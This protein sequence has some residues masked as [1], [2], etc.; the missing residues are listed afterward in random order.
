MQQVTRV[1]NEQQEQ[2][3]QLGLLLTTV[4]PK[5]RWLLAALVLLAVAGGLWWWLGYQPETSM[6]YKTAPAKRM[7]LAVTVTA[8]GKV[9]PKDK[10]ELSSELSG[11]I[12]DVFV[13]YNDRVSEGQKLAQL[14]TSKISATVLQRKSSLRSAQA[15]VKTARANLE[16]AQ[17]NHQYYQNVWA[18]SEG[19]FPSQQTLD[20]ARITLAKAEASLEQA[21]ASV[22][23]AKADLEFAESDL[24][25]STLV[26]PIDGVVL[27]R[28]VEKGQ[29]VASSLSAPTLFLLARD[30]KAMELLVDVDEAD[31]GVVKVGQSATFTVDAYR[32]RTFTAR[33][34][35]IRLATTEAS[36]STVVSYQTVLSVE[37]DD[38]LLLPGM[39]AV[40]DIRIASADNALVIDNAALRYRPAAAAN[41]AANGSPGMVGALLPRRLPGMGRGEKKAGEENSVSDQLRGRPATIW[42]LRNDQPQA[43]EIKTGISNGAYTQ[44][45]SG[46]LQEGDLVISDAVP[47][48]S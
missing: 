15:Q 24:A 8:T 46:D 16:E 21:L 37:N 10:V 47:V 45:V 7:D 39:T 4:N 42:V 27:S 48:R 40:T 25:K 41:T 5:L 28:S 20:N 43:V 1:N 44:V 2:A 22:D 19:K 31:I 35:Q 13:D 34:E 36:T 26:S 11:I 6:L 9:S 18:S 14:D 38:L 30:L 23:T 33:T 3:R 17:L 12:D 29:T 32:G